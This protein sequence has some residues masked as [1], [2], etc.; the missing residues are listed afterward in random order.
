M[1][2]L[3]PIIRRKRH[4][5]VPVQSAEAPDRL[6]PELQTPDKEKEKEKEKECPSTRTRDLPTLPSFGKAD[7]DEDEAPSPDEKVS[8]QRSVG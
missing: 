7:E 2:E 8:A 1:N 6:K 5:L 3:L 4:P